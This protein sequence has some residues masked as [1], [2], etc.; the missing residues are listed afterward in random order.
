MLSNVDYL[1]LD[2]FTYLLPLCTSAE[3]TEQAGLKKEFL[4]NAEAIKKNNDLD[5]ELR[6]NDVLLKGKREIKEKNVLA[7]RDKMNNI[8]QNQ[9]EV[10]KREEL[11]K[12][13]KEEAILQRNWKIYSVGIL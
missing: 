7:I 5:I 2:E 11:L 6:N 10:K 9:K 1:S 4:K 3:Y 13:L 8:A 12:K